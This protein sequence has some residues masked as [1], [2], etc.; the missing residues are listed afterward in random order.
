MSHFV[1]VQTKFRDKSALV[2]ALRRIWPEATITTSEQPTAIRGYY[3]VGC[4]C[5]VAVKRLSGKLRADKANYVNEPTKY[6]EGATK[7]GVTDKYTSRFG[8]VWGDVGFRLEADGTY[9]MHNDDLDA[10]RCELIAQEYA[11]EVAVKQATA[12]GYTVTEEK[13]DGVIH[14]KLSKWS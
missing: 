14:L 6:A 4:E 2:N 13:V 12:Q 1:K 11:R 5:S 7:S 3:G 8:P 9:S 10:H